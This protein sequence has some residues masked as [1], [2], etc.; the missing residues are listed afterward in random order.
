MMFQNIVELLQKYWHI[1]LLEGVKNTLILTFIAV[2]MGTILGSLVAMLKMSKFKLVRFIASVYIEI[3]RGTPILLQIYVFYFILPELFPLLNF[4]SFT[5]VAI[6]LCVNSAAYV[7]EVIRSGI[8]AVD[9]GQTEAARS[10]GMSQAQTMLRIILPQAVRNILPAL[11][12]EFIM[13]L[14][15]TSL[16]STFFI[17][18]LMTAHKIVAGAT[19][20]QLESLFIVGTIYLCITFPLSKL[21]GWFEKKMATDKSYKKHSRK[22]KL[23]ANT[24]EV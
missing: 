24:M 6:S 7:S 23:S 9:K 10:L 5:W 11:G 8:Q 14:K 19:Y 2:L 13:I 22:R 1:Y 4:T 18:D 15:E 17:G 12:N 20:L 3:I 16:A 21:V